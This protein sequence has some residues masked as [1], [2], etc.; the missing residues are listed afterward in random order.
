M[1]IAQEP[2][3][4]N[5]PVGM[6]MWARR[7]VT[8]VAHLQTKTIP[9]ELDLGSISPMDTDFRHLQSS[10]SF[11][12]FRCPMFQSKWNYLLGKFSSLFC[13]STLRKYRNLEVVQINFVL[14]HQ[15]LFIMTSHSHVASVSKLDESTARQHLKS[16]WSLCGRSFHQTLVTNWS[17]SWSW[18]TYSHPLCLMS[19]GPPILRY[20]YFKIWPWKFLVNTMRLVKGQGYIWPWIFKDQGHCQGQTHWSHLRPGVHSICLLFVSW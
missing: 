8:L 14:I 12:I 10:W 19:I 16:P 7:Q 9:I 3:A 11:I 20:S 2:A 15:A 13:I 18:M 1:V 4:L 6:P 17:Q 5:T